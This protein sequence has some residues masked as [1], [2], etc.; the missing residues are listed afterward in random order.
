MK[1]KRRIKYGMYS[2]I[3]TI[4]IILIIAGANVLVT[5]VGKKV[6]IKLDMT[7]NKLYGI[8]EETKEYLKTYDTPVDIYILSSQADQDKK[9]R[10]I[11]DQY[12]VAN[13]NI[14][15][16]NINPAENPSFGKKYV[17]AGESLVTDSVIIDAGERF[18]VYQYEDLYSENR[19]EINA[20]NK[21]TSALKYVSGK[22]SKTVY[23]I[24]GHNEKLLTGVQEQLENESYLSGELNL[25]TDDIP[26]DAAALIVSVPTV[27]FTSGE[28]AKMDSYFSKGGGAM[29]FLNTDSQGLNSLN[30]YISEWGISVNN[31]VVVEGDSSKYQQLAGQAVYFCTPEMKNSEITEPLINKNRLLG[32]IPYSR[33]FSINEV[34]GMEAAA[35]LT[36]TKNAYTSSDFDNLEQTADTET[37]EAIVAAVS[38]NAANNSRIFVTGNT[39]LYTNSPE[40]ISGKFGF[41]NYDYFMNILSYCEGED[42]YS[43][44]AKTIFGNSLIMN[45]TNIDWIFRICVIA[46]PLIVLAAGI[47]VWFRR[48]HL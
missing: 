8:S 19:T 11:L 47:A 15:V 9:I 34:N 29:F 17:S 31:T 30:S 20:E 26:Q 16:T 5:A 3:F 36:S 23:F 44:S 32:Y 25:L 43:A 21:I 13:A 42:S 40:V 33:T 39:F 18:R 48:R 6:P 38:K 7:Q 12:S 24:T 37:G 35:V 22:Q 10:M 28:L 4:V 1:D 46:I 45:K 2:T 27:D 14:K 41:A